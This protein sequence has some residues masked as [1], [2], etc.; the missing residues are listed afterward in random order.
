RI[1]NVLRKRIMKRESFRPVSFEELLLAT[2]GY[3]ISR[4]TV[5][6]ESPIIDKTLYE[7]ALR[8]QDIT[9]LAITRGGETIPNPPANIKMLSGD[10][11]ICFG[12]LDNIRGKICLM[13]RQ[14]TA[15]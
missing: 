7:S 5:C 9:V 4:I 6:P 14:P 13:P 12:R 10:E 11:L 15:D 8:S 1:T 2:G 3:G